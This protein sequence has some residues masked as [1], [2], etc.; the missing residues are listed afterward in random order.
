VFQCFS[1]DNISVDNYLEDLHIQTNNQFRQI[2]SYLKKQLQ[3]RI[4]YGQYILNE[5]A[6]YVFAF[7]DYASA[8]YFDYNISAKNLEK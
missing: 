4:E 2:N 5:I 8:M 1:Y 7:M 3:T 6:D